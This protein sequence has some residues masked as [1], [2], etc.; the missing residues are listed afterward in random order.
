MSKNFQKILKMILHFENWYLRFF[1]LAHL[2]PKKLLQMRLRNGLK[3]FVRA[4]SS[5]ISCFQSIT[6]ENEYFRYFNVMPGD[7][8]V[9]I[10]AN[11]GSFA[12]PVAYREPSVRMV[13]VEPLEANVS[14]LKKN[15]EA[16]KLANVSVVRAAISNSTEKLT[17][18]HG[19]GTWHASG[20]LYQIDATNSGLKED[21]PSKTL[22]QLFEEQ[23]I[24]HCDFLKMDCEGAEYKILFNLP[25]TMWNK[26]DK[27]ALEFHNF[28]AG[29]NQ[30]DIVKLLASKGY[31]TI[32]P[33]KW[34]KKE[35]GNIFAVKK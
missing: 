12:V 21:V 32:L 30:F 1:E 31:R 26:I 8:V 6:M 18:Y 14:L 13:V 24:E 28:E 4:Y 19:K 33:K 27:I 25:E 16:N 9:D 17:I 2:V 7:T 22:E 34:E 20:S 29:K 5:D 3:F 15:I 11:I 35:I 23:N 10:G